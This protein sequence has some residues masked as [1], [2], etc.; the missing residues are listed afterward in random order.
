MQQPTK[1][2]HGLAASISVHEAP[3]DEPAT[4]NMQVWMDE[5]TF[6]NE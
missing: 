1:T 3:G 2:M 5:D 6:V 4:P